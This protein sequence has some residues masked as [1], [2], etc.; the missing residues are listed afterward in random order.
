MRLFRAGLRRP[1]TAAVIR[2]GLTLFE[3]LVVVAI[4]AVLLALLLPAVQGLRAIARTTSC[5]N[6]LHQLGIALNRYVTIRQRSPTPAEMLDGV[7]YLIED[8]RA[9]YRCPEVWAGDLQSYGVNMCL[10]RIMSEAALIVMADGNVPVL[11]YRHADDAQWS[12]MIAPRHAGVVNALSFDGSVER[13]GPADINPYDSADGSRIREQWWEPRLPCTVDSSACGCVDRGVRAVYTP[14][15]YDGLT[16]PV[17]MVAPTLYLPFGIN[18]GWGDIKPQ[19]EGTH[20]FWN[21]KPYRPFTAHFT[22]SLW[23]KRA[24]N[25]RFLVSHDDAMSMRVDGRLVHQRG[26]WTGGPTSQT[27]NSAGPIALRAGTCVPIEITL[28]QN[29]PTDNH[30]WVMWES[31]SGVALQPI[32]AEHLCSDPY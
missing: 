9:V 18:Q 3:L 29:P 7:N 30:L 14:L 24:G 26:S 2:R 6:N 15:A 13:R 27:W 12:S 11:R 4:V 17:S 5:G 31:D 20:P 1:F 8:Q 21:R 28:T 23:V 22:G 10:N 32:P 25:Y 19:L 16:E